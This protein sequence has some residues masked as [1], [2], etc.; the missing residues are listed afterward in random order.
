MS[1]TKTPLAPLHL[2]LL[3]NMNRISSYLDTAMFLVGH[4]ETHA[5]GIELMELALLVI[6][7]ANDAHDCTNGEQANA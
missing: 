3:D 4:D 6:K 2:D 5:L 1:K 7:K